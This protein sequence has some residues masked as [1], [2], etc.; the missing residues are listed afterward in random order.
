LD[1]TEFIYGSSNLPSSITS[2][3]E[4]QFLDSGTDYSFDTAVWGGG[5][6]NGAFS[7]PNATFN[8]TTL[9]FAAQTLA[10][11]CDPN[12]ADPQ[13]TDQDCLDL[14]GYSAMYTQFFMSDNP[15]IDFDYEIVTIANSTSLRITKGNGD[16]AKYNNAPLSALDFLRH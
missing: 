15:P 3:V 10:V 6:I 9:Q 1:F 5:V 14:M 12:L 7:Y 8:A 4:L 2:D 13:V 11:C 16:N